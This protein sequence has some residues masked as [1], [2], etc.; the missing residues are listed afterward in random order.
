[1]P[2][3]IPIPQPG[4]R[5]PVANWHGSGDALALANLAQRHH[6]LFILC[7]QG[8]DARRLQEEMHWFAPTLNI[9]FLPDW[10]TLPYDQFSPHQDL[11]SERLSSLY[12]LATE[13]CDVIIVPVSSALGRLP[14]REW[15]TAHSFLLHRGQKLDINQLREQLINAGY[16]AT[17]QVAL[18]GEYCVR[19]G[20][21]DLYPMGSPL[22]YRIDLFDDTIDTLRTFDVDN[23]RSIYPVD[24]IRLLPAHEFPLDENGIARF[25]QHF[26]DHFDG[27]PSRKQPYRDISN[28]LAPAGIEYYLPLFFEHTADIF[29][30]LPRHTL[31]CLHGEM[32]DAAQHFWRDTLNRYRL[33]QYDKDRPILPPETLFLTAEQ[34]FVRLQPHAR[35]VIQSEPGEQSALLP[36]IAIERRA[37]DPLSK[38]R[39]FCH[40]FPGPIT[41]LAESAGRAETILQYLHEHELRAIPCENF[42]A[43]QSEHPIT[44]ATSPLVRGF[45]L[46]DTPPWALITEAELYA[47]APRIHGRNRARPTQIDHVLRD[48]SEIKP[49]DPVVHSEH[50]IGRYQGLINMDLGEGEMEFLLLEYAGGDKLYVPVAQLHLI[51]RYSGMASESVTL[52]RL[53]SGQWEKAKRRAMEQARDTA[54]ELLDLYARRAARQ[55]HAFQFRQQDYDAFVEGFGFEETPDQAAAI[56][57]VIQ[58][59]QSGKPMDRLVCGDVGFGKTE[60]A[61]RAA[62]VALM[63]GM[64]VAVLVPT[65]L[66]AEQHTQTFMDR[67][68]N[69]PVRIAE[70]SRFRTAREQ[71]Q[72]LTELADGR[73]DIVIGT[74]RLLQKDVRFKRL[75]LVIIDEEHRFGVRQ[76]EQ[77]KRLRAEVDVL[78]LTATPIPRTLGMALEG[79]RDFS[80]IS[81]PPQ[82]RLSIKT[83]VSRYAVG[84]IREAVLRELKRGGQIYFLHNDVDS[85]YHME[86]TLID[87]LPEASI[88]VA[89]GQMHERELEQAMRQFYQQ[90]VNLLLCTTIIETG[91]D[92]P[93]ANTI[94][95]N[96]AD[97]FGLA[98]LHQ[99]RGRVGRSHHQAYAYL[100]TPEEAALS[101]TAKK[102]L[103]ALQMMEDLGAGFQ[104]AMHDLE[105]RGAGEILGDAQSGSLQEI[106]FSL[107][108][109]MLNHAVKTLK[110]G[111]I[112]N[113]NEPLDIITD[114]NLHVPTLL[115]ANYCG[116]IHE[117]LVL[118]KR[119]S[120][121]TDTG[122][123]QD[124]REEMIDRFGKL[125]D[126]AQALMEAHTLR[127]L[128]QPLGIIKIN[129]TSEQ[130]TLQFIPQP[131]V[132]PQRLM[133][134]IHRNKHYQLAGPDKLRI[135]AVTA[136]WAERAQKIRH[137]FKELL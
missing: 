33:L 29:D 104:L 84:T 123:L 122:S 107:Y 3:S 113:L 10:E 121:C 125:P 18:P 51:G 106:G 112:L 130:T 11:V 57:A 74:H 93:N 85:I 35:I 88:R 83:F 48:L 67:F 55:G 65:T 94:I 69:W 63:D 103:E 80:T 64:Q 96:R 40:E 26:R 32:D 116:D 24:E 8:S 101:A 46:Q 17:S 7:A 119:L 73:I 15:L 81:T 13:Q 127:I 86:S 23:Q 128:A 1:M 52:S 90:R 39:R 82:K 97:R 105:I 102:R 60:V 19:G 47:G 30:Y 31:V 111:E 50:G 134:L 22:P 71:A 70:L 12:L 68:A 114:I 115:P 53:G 109:D 120:T 72:S 79:I 28:G 89:H 75:G 132:D 124:L 49:G 135:Q 61:L 59:L 66:L 2:F 87:L 25:R 14:P 91:I 43:C 27:D 34:F 44:I 56:E 4:H 21:I 45:I 16:Q 5:L 58:D 77:M 78:T 76:K 108:N 131:P 136:T 92:I 98:Q 42:S 62:F 36:D 129:A 54:A 118:Y 38:F 133:Q 126:P 9:R 110:R 137:F 117:R 41:L 20:I 99:L 95:I 37:E 6:P 100:L